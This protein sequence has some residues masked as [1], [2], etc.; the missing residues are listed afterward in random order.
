MAEVDTEF[1]WK[2][3]DTQTLG[4]E[5][6]HL[7]VELGMSYLEATIQGKE[8]LRAIRE[9]R[10]DTYAGTSLWR[11]LNAWLGNLDWNF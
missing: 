6:G 10:L 3:G 2:S 9:I 5:W 4:K 11:A 8:K 7:E 1:C